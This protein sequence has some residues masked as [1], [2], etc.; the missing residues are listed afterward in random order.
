MINR[1]FE[2]GRRKIQSSPKCKAREKFASISYA[3]CLLTPLR[4]A[5]YGLYAS[6]EFFLQRSSWDEI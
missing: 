1:A 6:K 3:D 2:N 4:R 5:A